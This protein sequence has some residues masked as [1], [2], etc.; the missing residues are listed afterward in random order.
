MTLLAL[1]HADRELN[2]FTLQFL[3]KYATSLN[4][5]ARR[6]FA[7]FVPALCEVFLRYFHVWPNAVRK[8]CSDLFMV[9]V[10]R[11][12]ATFHETLFRV[13]R[14]DGVE[15]VHTFLSPAQRELCASLFK[16]LPGPRLKAL[17]GDLAAIANSANTTDVLLSY[18]LPD[19]V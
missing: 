12:G 11:H 16:A 8:Y 1:R 14:N 3:V 2:K 4:E 10:E 9:L 7:C 15:G 5:E 17:L 13:W 18:K 6:R 19:G